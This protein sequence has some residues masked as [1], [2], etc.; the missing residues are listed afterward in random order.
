LGDRA[1][2]VHFE[3]PEVAAYTVLEKTRHGGERVDGILA[4]GDRPAWRRLMCSRIGNDLQPS[5]GRGGLPKQIADAGGVSGCGLLVPWFRAVAL[6][7]APEP[8]LLEISYPCVLK[9]LSLSAST[10]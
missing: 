5:G 6:Q 2:A 4:L 10:E 8:A 3:S 1:I 7:P 9:P